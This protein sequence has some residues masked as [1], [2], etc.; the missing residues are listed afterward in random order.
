[1]SQMSRFLASLEADA[2][3]QRF[4]KATIYLR[5]LVFGRLSDDHVVALA[6]LHELGGIYS[7]AYETAQV[8]HD[9]AAQYGGQEQALRTH[10]LALGLPCDVSELEPCEVE[11]LLEGW[12]ERWCTLP[13]PFDATLQAFIQHA[14]TQLSAAAARP[15]AP[16]YQTQ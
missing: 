14:E 7:R 6:V 3:D 16:T 11:G 15:S 8:L 4:N 13:S 2:E 9:P 12:G 1:M 10:L 5:T